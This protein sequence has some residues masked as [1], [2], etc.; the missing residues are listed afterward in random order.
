[1]DLHMRF[2]TMDIFHRHARKT[3]L[4]PVLFSL[5]NLVKPGTFELSSMSDFETP[6]LKPIYDAALWRRSHARVCPDGAGG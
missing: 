2:G 3:A 1:M 4:G 6:G 5:A